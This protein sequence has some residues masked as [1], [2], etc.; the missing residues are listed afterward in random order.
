M[1]VIGAGLPRTATTTQLAVLEQLGFGP[2]Y[3]MRNV[4]GRL[5]RPAFRRGRAWPRATP[6]GMRSSAASQSSCDFPASRYY[7]ELVE[8][9]PDAKVLLSVRS[10]EGWVRSMRE[11]IWPMYFG[12]CL[13]HHV[14]QARRQVDRD[15]G[16]FLAL[17]T[18]MC[19][20]ADTGAI[21]ARTTPTTPSSPRSWS[22]GTQGV[23]TRSPRATA[24]LGPRRRLG[25]AVRVPRGAG[26]RGASAAHQRHRRV[27]GGHVR[28]RPRGTQRVVGAARAPQGIAARRRDRVAPVR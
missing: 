18:H 28:R 12:D 19:W 4:F 17:M 5:R 20:D 25:A 11:T 13:L 2:C 10:A 6:T 27:Q 7:R 8:H 14:N 1:K 24:R 23:T 3:H 26:A 15:W 21:A 16:R 9:Y 22:A